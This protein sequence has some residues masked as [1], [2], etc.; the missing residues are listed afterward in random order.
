MLDTLKTSLVLRPQSQNQTPSNVRSAIS[1][2]LHIAATMPDANDRPLWNN[3]TKLDNVG[4]A[5]LPA[6]LKK[7]S[8]HPL[9]LFR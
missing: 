7:V 3:D 6:E 4:W 8:F 5:S 9:I 2:I 1:H